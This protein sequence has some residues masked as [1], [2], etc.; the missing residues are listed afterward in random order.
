MAR[1]P[2]E[3]KVVRGVTLR[4]DPA[5]E[6]CFTIG[7]HETEVRALRDYSLSATRSMLHRE[8]NNE[9]QNAEIAAQT[10]VD[11]PDAPWEVRL[12]L[13]RQCW[14]ETRHARMF[15]RRIH[16]LGGRKGEAPIKNGDWGI[17]GMIDSLPGRLLVQ[18]R[19]FE[20]GVMDSMRQ[21]ARGFREEGDDRTAEVFEA[22]LADEIQHVRF[23]NQYLR[24]ATSQPR[25]LMQMA[26][27][28]NFAV[29]ALKALEPKPGDRSVDDVDLVA[30]DHA[31]AVNVEDRQLAGFSNAEIADLVGQERWGDLQPRSREGS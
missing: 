18:N 21:V 1:G 25:V 24:T 12:Q 9:V 26:A 17:V 23:A 6:P 29:G 10:L 30:V 19:L 13:A 5:R 8:Y 14:D 11:F 22:I 28:M 20:G 16:E 3:T 31:I 15:L 27:A 2:V 4:R 7:H